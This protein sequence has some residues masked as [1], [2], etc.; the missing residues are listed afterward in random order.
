MKSKVV[1]GEAGNAPTTHVAHSIQN[2]R[3]KLSNYPLDKIYKFD[4]TAIFFKLSPYRTYVVP[5]E[6]TT[7]RSGAKAIRAK[8]RVTA[9]ICTSANG[10]VKIPIAV[11]GKSG[12]LRPFR[13]EAPSF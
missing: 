6:N 1:Y 11:I 13:N 2:L 5:E 10:S 3:E 4:E 8:D 7:D 9:I 12:N